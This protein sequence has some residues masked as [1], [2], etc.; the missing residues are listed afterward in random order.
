MTGGDLA[1]SLV[2]AADPS[3]D[4]IDFPL[5]R[6][7]VLAGDAVIVAIGAAVAA[8]PHPHRLLAARDRLAAAPLGETEPA[9]VA[10]ACKRRGS[11]RRGGVRCN[12]GHADESEDCRKSQPGSVASTGPCDSCVR[13]CHVP[14]ISRVAHGASAFSTWTSSPGPAG[15]PAGPRLF[16]FSR[17]AAPAPWSSTGSRRHLPRGSRRLR[18]A[19]SA[20]GS[21]RDRGGRRRRPWRQ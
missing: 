9:E 6:A 21:C 15:R 20:A 18:R 19:R 7:D 10:C 13:K 4:R 16:R 12:G 14:R 2:S 5:R 1:G 8:A 3:A 17:P 11:L